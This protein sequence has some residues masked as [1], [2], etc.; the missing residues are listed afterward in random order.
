MREGKK[1]NPVVCEPFVP[2]AAQDGVNLRI[3]E[4]ARAHGGK[5]EKGSNDA[6]FSFIQDDSLLLTAS[7]VQRVIPQLLSKTEQQQREKCQT[8]V[9]NDS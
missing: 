6:P 4:V 9:K 2:F 5:K 7:G 1:E 3:N 8:R